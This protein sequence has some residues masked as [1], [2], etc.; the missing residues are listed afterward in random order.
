M[1][2][3]NAGAFQRRKIVQK[4]KWSIAAERTL[5]WVRKGKEEKDSTTEEAKTFSQ[6]RRKR[7][8]KLKIPTGMEFYREDSKPAQLSATYFWAEK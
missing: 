2:K 6:P 5:E 1:Q 3:R 8:E 4:V 7:Q